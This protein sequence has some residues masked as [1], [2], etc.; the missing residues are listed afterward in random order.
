M[1]TI[2]PSTLNFCFDLKDLPLRIRSVDEKDTLN[3]IGGDVIYEHWKCELKGV[4]ISG[5][6]TPPLHKGLTGEQARAKCNNLFKSCNGDCS[7]T[8]ESSSKD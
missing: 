7:P 3:L 2:I 6:T 1:K 4:R 8:K 5:F